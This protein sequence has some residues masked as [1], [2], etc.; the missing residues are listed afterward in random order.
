VVKIRLRRTGTKGRPYYRIVIAHSSCG[1]GGKFVENLGTYDPVV[2]PT[3]ITLDEE[4]A[5]EW[6]LKGA[7]PSETVAYILSKV[8]V[9]GKF[10]EQRPNLKHQYRFLDKRTAA[11]SVPSVIEP[12]AAAPA[13]KA[14]PKPEPEPELEPAPV[15]V[16]EPVAEATVT[17]EDTPAAEEKSE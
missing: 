15:E 3:K 12:Q 14:E 10:L 2:K 17:A 9:L 16:A 4:K 13:P 1:R 11:I 5:M 8:G 7:Q 6:L